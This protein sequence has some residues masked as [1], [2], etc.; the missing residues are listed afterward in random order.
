[1][2]DDQLQADEEMTLFYKRQK[3]KRT[4]KDT[5]A[6]EIDHLLCFPE[7]GEGLPEMTPHG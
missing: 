6:D 7:P 4:I 2:D 3:A 5:P 1:L